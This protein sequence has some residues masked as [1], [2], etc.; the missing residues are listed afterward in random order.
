MDDLVEPLDN[1]GMFDKG[2]D[3]WVAYSAQNTKAYKKHAKKEQQSK[4]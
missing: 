4:H 1:C 2:D 3:L